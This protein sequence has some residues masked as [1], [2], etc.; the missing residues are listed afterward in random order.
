MNSPASKHY[1]ETCSTLFALTSEMR[2]ME[3]RLLELS[4]KATLNSIDMLSLHDPSIMDQFKR[5]V[6]NCD[7]CIKSIDERQKANE[8]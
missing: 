5:N 4:V 7:K 8:I 6:E 3:E 2:Q 1:D